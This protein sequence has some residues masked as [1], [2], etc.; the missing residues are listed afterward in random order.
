MGQTIKFLFGVGIGIT[1]LFPPMLSAQFAF[2]DSLNG[3]YWAQIEPPSYENLR[4]AQIVHNGLGYVLGSSGTL[5]EYDASRPQRW[6]RLPRPEPYFIWH[7]FALA[8][9]N[10]W[11][12]VKVPELYKLALYRW[13]G[14]T[15]SSVASPNI[16]NIRNFFFSSADEGWF[17]CEYGEI[18]HYLRGQWQQEELPLFLHADYM[19]LAADSALYVVC[20]AP[21]QEAV[22][23]RR[24][25]KWQVFEL[26]TFQRPLMVMLSPLNHFLWMNTEY[27]HRRI[28]VFNQPVWLLPLRKIEFFSDSFGY[29]FA[30][31]K[32]YALKDTAY[33][34][35]ADSP[36]TIFDL[37]IFAKNFSWIVGAYG[38]MLAPQRQPSIFSPSQD[39]FFELIE[40]GMTNV[41]GMAVLQKRPGVVSQLYFAQTGRPNV[42]YEVPEF[43][44]RLAMTDQAERLNLAGEMV[45]D[46]LQLSNGEKPTNYDQAIATGDLNGDGRDDLVVTSMYGHPFVYFNSGHDYYFDA[47]VYSGLQKWGSV[48]QRPMLANLFDADHDGDLD[49]FI[50]CQYRSDAFWVNDGRGRFKE[51]TVPAGLSTE[52]GGIGGY[53]ADF[54]GN[55]W[56]DLYVT[57]VGRPNL[58]YHNQG[59][60][61]LSGL[62][63]FVDFS[64]ESGAACWQSLKQS[65]G[66]AVG[67]YDNDGDFD[68]F[69][70]NLESGNRLLQNDG[71]GFFV[72]VTARAGLAGSDRSV[73]ATF[74]DADN[75]GDLDLIVANKGFERFYKN[76][77]DGH[78]AELSAYLDLG[79]VQGD[80]MLNNSR[81]F[82]G[83][84]SGTL[85]FD[86]DDDADLDVMVS[87]YDVGLFVFKNGVNSPNSAIQIFPEGLVSNRSAVGA[88][89]VLYRSGKMGRPDSLV[90]SRLIESA[91]SYGCSPAK[92]AHFGVAP[93]ETYK[94]RIIFPSGIVREVRD[95]HG[96]ERRVVAELDGLAAN[97]IKTRRALANL[98]FGYRS[99]QRLVLLGLGALLLIVML[100]FG[101]R[102]LGLTAYDQK[103]L[104][105][106]FSAS[107]LICLVLWFARTQ[108][109]FVVRPLTVSLGL[110]L[111]MIVIWRGKRLYQARPASI[112]MLQIRLNA[113]GHGSLI[114]QL[115]NRLALFTEN[116]ETGS[117]LPI[118]ARQKLAEVV[119]GL[120]HFLNHEIRAILTYQY[121]NNFAM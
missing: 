102:R 97:M 14:E 87:N 109:E 46:D 19:A 8:A 78:F 71:K 43:H 40:Y 116:L 104:T 98:L 85:A 52:G 9:N 32:I 27:Q 112:E 28:E 93:N 75:D 53:V 16:Y 62:P 4:N 99:R 54:D 15:W 3:I 22:L 88:R 70:C 60:D 2:Y 76:Q 41:Y 31:K 120:Q 63:R 38:F 59:P 90:G 86:F 69:V 77:G 89:V 107:L 114:H 35:V 49:L 101:K 55:G 42:A 25:G 83:N 118:A 94:A 56:E 117:D 64:A 36:V 48:L 61:S 121:G 96:G 1:F 103:R 7:F 113:F 81:L 91:N 92:V 50:A 73:G 45:Y 110:T 33:N 29:G 111:M 10:I 105:I 84:S 5:Y 23:K 44:N 47:T 108:M 37:S 12:A 95:L 24:Q 21:D 20:E 26:K 65:Q 6:H 66:A 13:N 80:V 51:V 119:G 82:G 11:A 57:R 34:E 100:W 72:D 18:W 30:N 17:A 39:R 74:F 106:I 79:E 115:M 58:F 68:L 67:D